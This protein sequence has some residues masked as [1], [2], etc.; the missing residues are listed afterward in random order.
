MQVDFGDCSPNRVD[1]YPVEG[2][3]P[4]TTIMTRY[5]S[6]AI[7]NWSDNQ[8]AERH[9]QKARQKALNPG[10]QGSLARKAEKLNN[11]FKTRF[12]QSVQLSVGPDKRLLIVK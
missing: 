3:R 5:V 12:I 2:A 10:W 11:Q 7:K 4:V 6:R 9:L 1:C 8:I